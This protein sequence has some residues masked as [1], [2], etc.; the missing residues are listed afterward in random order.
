[1]KLSHLSLL[2]HRA[3]VPLRSAVVDPVVSAALSIIALI[4]LF[5]KWRP[6]AQTLWQIRNPLRDAVLSGGFALSLLLV[7]VAALLF[8]HFELF[9]SGQEWRSAHGAAPARGDAVA[10]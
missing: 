2:I 9:G 10:S 3:P 1:M 4:L 7:L 8:E 5:W 6:V